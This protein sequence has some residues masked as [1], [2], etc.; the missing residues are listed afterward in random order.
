M[1]RVNQSYVIMGDRKTS[2]PDVPGGFPPH[3]LGPDLTELQRNL[4]Q[5]GL[6]EDAAHPD[7]FEQFRAWYQMAEAAQIFLPDAM[8]LATATPE[9]KPS[10]RMVLLKGVDDRGFIFFTNYESRKGLELAANPEAAL[11]LYWKELAR[12]VRIEGTVEKI[13]SGESDAYF[14][15]R[16]WGSRVSAC[17]SPQSQVISSREVL[18][19]RMHEMMSQ[20]PGE[21]IPRPP[22][23]GGYRV[24]PAIIEFWQG[25]PNRLHDRLCYRRLPDGRW[26]M[27]RLSP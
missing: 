6:C 15:T 19:S 13:T 9:G 17:I 5:N 1:V 10:A 16:P 4:A 3:R 8:T 2:E 21:Q 24:L 14:Q 23:W 18:E 25:R 22:H 7:P 11:V 27:E 26:C 20:H 12:Q